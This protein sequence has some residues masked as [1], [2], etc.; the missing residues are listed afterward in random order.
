MNKIEFLTQLERELKKHNVSDI[1]EI[2]DDYREYFDQQISIGQKEENIASYIGE[3]QS[4][5]DDY[6]T[7]DKGNHKK[8]WNNSGICGKMSRF[9][10][11]AEPRNWLRE[12]RQSVTSLHISWLKSSKKGC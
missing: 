12:R 3:I 6:V 7:I 10:I 4:I 9:A 2:I 11:D 1:I 5:V 8:C